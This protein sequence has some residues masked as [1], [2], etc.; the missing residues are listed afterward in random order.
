M[1]LVAKEIDNNRVELTPK[2]TKYFYEK[3]SKIPGLEF[4]KSTFRWTI[5]T[6]QINNLTKELDNI[7]SFEVKTNDENQNKVTIH[8]NGQMVDV[9]FKYDQELIQIMR[10]IDGFKYNAFDKKWS[11]PNE[12]KTELK[13]KLRNY[14]N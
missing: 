12:K 5:P 3:V 4:N 11:V 2:L 7:F 10:T 13:F 9:I 6:D 8:D 14:I 1:K